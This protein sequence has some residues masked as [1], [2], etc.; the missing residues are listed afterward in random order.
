MSRKGT[1]KLI[2][3]APR[4]GNSM[5]RWM[6]MDQMDRW[7]EGQP[8]RPVSGL[9]QTH[10]RVG[11]AV[12]KEIAETAMEIALLLKSTTHC[13]EPTFCLRVLKTTIKNHLWRLQKAWGKLA[14]KL[15][16]PCTCIFLTA[17]VRIVSNNGHGLKF[18]GGLKF[19]INGDQFPKRLFPLCP[20]RARKPTAW[21]AA[22]L[23]MPQW[24]R[25][26][27]V[28]GACFPDRCMSFRT[29]M[30]ACD[31]LFSKL[32]AK[33][34]IANNIRPYRVFSLA[35]IAQREICI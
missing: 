8:F 7:K 14:L 1:A 31:C 23:S 15:F 4:S 13:S 9:I 6:V 16:L 24:L 5:Y 18:I 26:P 10:C 12:D 20:V 3:D 28:L 21:T 30:A 32:K 27:C 29:A 17:R 34:K 2:C 35:F 19:I 11:S 25:L 33:G 22:R